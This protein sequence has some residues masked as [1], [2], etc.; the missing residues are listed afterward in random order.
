MH[1]DD[2]KEVDLAKI[3]SRPLGRGSFGFPL[4]W[5][6]KGDARDTPLPG[7]TL[8]FT[9][10]PV[11][12]PT[13]GDVVDALEHLENAAGKTQ[14]LVEAPPNDPDLIYLQAKAGA[15]G[16]LF[17]IL[18]H[19]P[20]DCRWSPDPPVLLRA[21]RPQQ[22]AVGTTTH[23][24]DQYLQ[25]EDD[26]SDKPARGF[27]SES[28]LLSARDILELA[29]SSLAFRPN[30]TDYVW[31][32]LSYK[33][34]PEIPKRRKP[35]RP[36]VTTAIRSGWPDGAPELDITD[37]TIV[38]SSSLRVTT[39][40]G[41]IVIDWEKV[42][43]VDS[44]AVHFSLR[45]ETDS[46]LVRELTDSPT[47]MGCDY[48]SQ[49]DQFTPAPLELEGCSS[50][51]QLLALIRMLI[52]PRYANLYGYDA[53]RPISMAEAI[54]FNEAWVPLAPHWNSDWV[55]DDGSWPVPHYL[56]QQHPLPECESNELWFRQPAYELLPPPVSPQPFSTNA[57][58]LQTSPLAGGSH[59]SLYRVLDQIET[60]HSLTLRAQ[61]DNEHDCYA[62]RVYWINHHIG[63]L[64]RSN[65]KI[66][67][68]L[69]QQ[70]APL[71]AEVAEVLFEDACDLPAPI[72]TNI[73]IRVLLPV[74]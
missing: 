44:G 64:P 60:G 35:W 63:Y 45:N 39:T 14:L 43:I 74:T 37:V 40:R 72:P 31:N 11:A 61:P 17:E 25:S 56:P 62:V 38:G 13:M 55:S 69:L 51:P 50:H 36:P 1:S 48:G 5:D 66:A 7:H 67:S 29:T 70:G 26:S 3:F 4:T 30:D 58:R 57:Y 59:A 34:D 2:A 20:R 24:R 21:A 27:C 8:Y 28:E 18:C 73:K 19:P 6:Q 42:T 71:T 49:G 16:Y 52:M 10:Q 68:R 46:A 32:T 22:N 65:N 53:P 15:D 23:Q 12:A 9:G 41:I 33:E 47:I 54:A